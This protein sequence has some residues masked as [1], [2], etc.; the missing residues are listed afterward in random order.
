MA[1]EDLQVAAQTPI[2]LRSSCAVLKRQMPRDHPEGHDIQR[3]NCITTS[4]LQNSLT[5]FAQRSVIALKTTPNNARHS[6]K[7]KATLNDAGERYHPPEPCIKAGN[8][9]ESKG[10]AHPSQSPAAR[11]AVPTL[12]AC[13]RRPGLHGSLQEG[14]CSKG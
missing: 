2:G 10:A 14:S 9:S 5:F 6:G 13:G 11:F 8:S 4:V 7:Y 3:I 12:P 1:G